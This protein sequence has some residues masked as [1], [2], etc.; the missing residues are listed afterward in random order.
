MKGGCSEKSLV[1]C[2]E[3]LC[4]ALPTKLCP[5]PLA[6]LRTHCTK[7]VD[8]TQCCL[9]KACSDVVD[10]GINPPAATAFFKH[11][12]WRAGRCENWHSVRKCFRNDQTE[13]FRM[14]R[15]YEQV[16]VEKNELLIIGLDRTNERN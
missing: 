11:W 8:I 4:D 7:F 3:L 1:S 10:R 16:S 9:A 6:A 5:D 13:I 14:A 2:Y 12:P 15:K